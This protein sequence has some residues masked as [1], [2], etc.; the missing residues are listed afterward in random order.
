MFKL[1]SGMK[2][3]EKKRRAI[4]SNMVLA[5][6]LLLVWQV[7]EAD[8]LD[9]PPIRLMNRHGVNMASGRPSPTLVDVSIGDKALG[10]THSISTYTGNMVNVGTADEHMSGPDGP[11]DK[12][13]GVLRL[14]L[15]HKP[16]GQENNPSAWVYV[17]RAF[18]TEGSFDFSVNSDGTFTSYN[19]DPRQILE[20]VNDSA[21]Y[22][23]VW[24]KPDGSTS[25][26]ASYANYAPTS[27]G[28][29]ADIPLNL[30]QMQ[31]ANGFTVNILG[32]VAN[33]FTNTGYQLKY[34]YSAQDPSLPYDDP[35][36]TSIPPIG[37]GSESPKYVVAINNTVDYCDPS[38][39]TQYPDVNSACPGLTV[40][41][42]PR[43]TYLWPSGMPRAMFLQ[44][45]SLVVLD[46]EGGR[47]EYKHRPYAKPAQAG[48]PNFR[49]VRLVGIKSSR[50]TV[51]EVTYDYSTTDWIANGTWKV[52]WTPGA[53]AT[54]S[55]STIGSTAWGYT[56]NQPYQPLN[57]VST[58]RY[59]Q[60][61]RTSLLVANYQWGLW[62]VNDLDYSAGWDQTYKNQLQ[63]LTDNVTGVKMAYGYDDRYN[64]TSVTKNGVTVQTAGYPATCSN[65]KTCNQATWVKDGNGNQT[66]FEY[67]PNSGQISRV[68]K[69]A[70]MSGGISVRPEIRY[71]YTPLY[72]YYK[73]SATG[74]A[75]AS[76]PVYLLT[77]ERT[78]LTS[79]T[80]ADGSGCT[81][82]A[83]DEIITDYDYGPANA[84]NNLL[85]RGVTVSA[86]SEGAL[87]TRRT[88]Y[89]YDNFGNRIG[90]I[91]PKAGLASCY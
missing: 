21:G 65:R 89:Q 29:N 22:G 67:D 68:R 24:T 23:I 14:V 27:T 36:N 20:K 52:W 78:C 88:C 86:Y 8:R 46:S 32:N 17:M 15:H 57:G 12:F 76:T 16:I 41:N 72:A 11:K 66:D 59:N 47:T 48:D 70:V 75:Q 90:E 4:D 40:N 13:A 34:V 3:A 45:N 62:M 61:G 60:G 74:Y 6:S 87:Q 18:D 80:I 79:A 73:T 51:S 82:G 10:L 28:Q 19:G 83:A 53:I 81:G 7:A 2:L 54:L 85:L 38:Y 91:K 5:A 58:D 37:W 1:L 55:L 35:T 44:E 84:P 63:Y 39:L 64:I 77:R 69:P 25:R 30:T 42:W 56:L 33:V 49:A 26:F 50:A 43:A 31:A 9:P 71:T